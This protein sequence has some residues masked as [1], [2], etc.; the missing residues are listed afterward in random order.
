MSTFQGWPPAA[1]AW[2][3]GLLEDNSKAYFTAHRATYD[4]SVKGPLLTLLDDLSDEFG[5]GKVFRPNRDGRFSHDKSPYKT[6]TAAVAPGDMHQPGYWVEV[7]AEG[8]AAGAG[9]HGGERSRVD[10]FRA[11]VDDEASGKDLERIVADLTSAGLEIHGE[12][13]KSAPRGYA[14]DHPRITLLR[15]THIIAVR[16]EPVGPL[17]QSAAAGDWVRDTWRACQ[18]LVTWLRQHV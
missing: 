6:N 7:S 3:E 8:M 9:F 12:T 4:E 16:R 17:V 18:P 15:H 10:Q 2:F 11:A 14:K 1:F 13:L 5:P